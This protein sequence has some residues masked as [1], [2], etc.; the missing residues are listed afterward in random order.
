M[1][2][3][4]LKIY[5][6]PLSISSWAV[7]VVSF[8][9]YLMTVDPSVSYWDCP[10]Y[11]ITASKLQIGHPPGN[12]TW[13]LAMRVATIPF[14][15]EMH[16][17]VINIFS[18]IFMAF[19]S[20]FL[21]RLIFMPIRLGCRKILGRGT[22]NFSFKAN[23]LSIF[24]SVGASLC[25]SFC[26]SAWFSAVEAE[27]YA[28]SA[29][30]TTL[31]LWIMMK[32]WFEPSPGRRKRLLILEAYLIGLSIGVHQLNLLCIPVYILI[33]LYK[34]HR[35]KIEPYKVFFWL[36]VGLCI[37]GLILKVFMP[38]VLELASIFELLTVNAWGWVYNSGLMI[39]LL[40]FFLVV[41]F[42]LWL[43]RRFGKINTGIWMLF[44][45]MIGYS[46]FG[47]ILIRANA[48]PPL[49][50]G[51][52]DNV[53]SLTSYINRDLYSSAPLLYG[54]TP[55]SRPLLDEEYNDRHPGVKRYLL[56]KGKRKYRPYEEEAQLNPVSGFLTESDSM[57]NERVFNQEHGYLIEDYAFRQEMTP[58]MNMWFPRMTSQNP[59]HIKAYKD[60]GGYD[61]E[62]PTYI[63]NL[64][65][66]TSYQVFYMYL[67]YLL[68][69][70]VGRQNDF[71][72]TG[73]INHG[74][75]I[76][77]LGLID[78]AMLGDQS[79]LPT[80]IGKENPGHNVYYG[81]PFLL[82]IV[83]IIYLA[84]G[85]RMK[86]RVLSLI[87]IF[88]LLTGLAIVVYLNQTPGE[89]RERDYTFLGSYMAFAMWIAAGIWAIISLFVKRL[90]FV[91]WVILT[92][93]LSMFPATLMAVENFDDHDRSGRYETEFYA[94]SLLEFDQPSI[95]FSFGD[96][97]TFPLWYASEIMDK[98]PESA[99]VDISY[100]TL[101]SYVENLKKQG[102][103]GFN[104][105]MPYGKAAYGAYS[106]V[107]LPEDSLGEAYSLEVLLKRLYSSTNAKPKLEGSLINFPTSKGDSVV[108]SLRELS[109]GK[110]YLTFKQLM[111]LDMIASQFETDHPRVIYFPYTLDKKFYGPLDT[112]LYPAPFGKIYAPHL[113]ENQ[114]KDVFVRNLQRE[115]NK[116][117]S[118]DL[119]SHYSD[120]VTAG[121]TKR[122][123]AD[124]IVAANYLLDNGEVE[125]SE[126][127]VEQIEEKFPFK[128][129]PAG[130]YKFVDRSLN[131]ME[132]YSQLLDRLY[133]TTSNSRYQQ[134][135][136]ELKSL[137]EQRKQEW[138]DYF[139]SLSPSQRALISR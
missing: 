12:P 70:F 42:A 40:L 45:L 63:E 136:E 122:Y 77:G 30:L 54:Q 35:E 103:R 134:I 66:F 125:M 119:K 23:L 4:P 51:T 46:S 74:N 1:A 49:N 135:V 10:E 124:L 111:L 69:N 26:D 91:P 43:T 120:P 129:Y 93:I 138:V 21:C 34:K 107:S 102:K 27:V 92:F 14:P 39:F 18:G 86:R 53:F 105:M 78:A 32:W 131:D 6:I 104:T 59:N 112:L 13:T 108:I 94:S 128:I 85:N 126:S 57:N 60:W 76:T 36:L 95:I 133:A 80:E 132:E 22:H 100:L 52:P 33:W 75:F 29:M 7:F 9:V 55:N 31:S 89:P 79:K 115:I 88:F 16:A 48:S 98:G 17:R 65:Y 90:S 113:S 81:I 121:K 56:K 28:M 47:I 139:Y 83:G 68:W 117:H 114:I 87:F 130:I 3:S 25:F 62:K 19:A 72:S 127:I 44:F 82:G 110:G 84:L 96:N 2:S 109:E 67:R 64:R 24:I 37:V 8:V 106:T 123:R 101:P 61:G 71:H 15:T 20:F 99:V 58:E 50:I 97:S 137:K 41:F 38:G 73:E 5:R 11:V 116:L 118:L